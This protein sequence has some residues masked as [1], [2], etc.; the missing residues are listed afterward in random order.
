MPILVDS[1]SPAYWRDGELH[2]FNSAG[3]SY[4]TSAQD[5]YSL[6][7]G[8]L[9]LV[10]VDRE[11]H[12][13][14]W[15]ESVWQDSDGTLY[16]WY[17]H[18]T[19]GLCPG[20]TLSV[21][22]IGALV[23]TDGG[24]TFQDQGVVL[25][26]ADP[27]DCSARNGFFAG[28]HGDFSVILDRDSAYFYFLFGNYG[29]PLEG[30]GVAVARMAFEDRA[31]PAGAVWKYHAGAWNEPGL[32]GLVTPVFPAKVAWQEA[33][34]D[35]LWGPSVHW[36]TYLRSYVVLLNHACCEPQWPQEGIYI[37]FNPDLGNPDAWTA[38]ARI[39]AGKDAGFAPAF[40]PQVLG[41]YVDESDTIAGQVARFW[42]KGLSKWEIVFSR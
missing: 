33:N 19:A 16:A 1:N 23:S 11:E 4:M 30:Q 28:G 22:D 27:I 18:E 3:I 13:P 29:G 35:A 34:A 38:P 6:L 36:N 42:V 31:N 7:D 17:H 2:I 15:I 25:A 14:M 10:W 32:G 41:L 5:Q 8:S 40:Y 39:L 20:S 12:F 9:D 37:A 21:P 24:K 26:S